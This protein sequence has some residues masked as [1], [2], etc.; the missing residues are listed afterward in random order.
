[1][2]VVNFNSLKL[3]DEFLT[4][5]EKQLIEKC[6][7]NKWLKQFNLK[8][9][10]ITS[11][12][13]Q[14]TSYLLSL[15]Y[16]FNTALCTIWPYYFS[17]T[18][19]DLS[20]YRRDSRNNILNKLLL[21]PFSINLQIT[22]KKLYN[23]ALIRVNNTLNENYRVN[24]LKNYLLPH[25]NLSN[26]LEIDL[27]TIFIFL[28]FNIDILDNLSIDEK[29]QLKNNILIHMV[30]QN[31]HT[32]WKEKVRFIIK[33]VDKLNEYFPDISITDT[34]QNEVIDFIKRILRKRVFIG[35]IMQVANKLLQF[36]DKD[37]TDINKLMAKKVL[38]QIAK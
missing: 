33:Y 19:L 36:V 21:N 6:R 7:F 35:E 18:K 24:I 22:H 13:Y 25:V 3:R 23:E 30:N 34:A 12:S 17:Q 31:I 11:Y 38:N 10:D 4:I 26:M 2:P 27:K 1:M 29:S 14:N 15:Q 32:F 8:I 9:S 28:S 37:I 20:I 16:E 5:H